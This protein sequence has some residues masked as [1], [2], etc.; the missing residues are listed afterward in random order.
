MSL[1]SGYRVPD[2]PATTS[3]SSPGGSHAQGWPSPPSSPTLDR[4]TSATSVHSTDPFSASAKSASFG[5]LP[6]RMRL[7]RAATAAAPE[8]A[9]LEPQGIENLTLMP[10]APSDDAPADAARA[11][12]LGQFFEQSSSEEAFS[13]SDDALAGDVFSSGGKPAPR[14]FTRTDSTDPLSAIGPAPGTARRREASAGGASPGRPHDAQRRRFVGTSPRKLTRQRGAPASWE[15]SPPDTDEEELAGAPGAEPAHVAEE[16]R[17]H[18]VINRIYDEG[19][20]DPAVLLGGCHVTQVPAAVGDLQHYVAIEPLRTNSGTRA[21]SS[22]SS[23]ARRRAQLQFF[24]WDNALTRLPSALFQL[25]NL[26]VLSLRKNKLTRLPPAIGELRHLRELN[27]GGNALPFLPAEVQRLQLDTFTFTPNPFLP[28]PPDAPLTTRSAFGRRYVDAMAAAMP[29]PPPRA[30][31]FARAHSEA[32]VA[33]LRRA[34]PVIVRALGALQRTRLPSLLELCIVRLLSADET[35]GMLLENYETGCLEHLRYALDA[36]VVAQ[37]EA[38]RRSAMRSWGTRTRT[39]ST[40]PVQKDAWFAGAHFHREDAPACSPPA[41][42][43][44]SAM[45][46]E[47]MLEYA[48]DACTNPWF[49]RDPAACGG[50]RGDV[51]SHD[52]PAPLDTAAQSPL[53]V[54][55]FEQRLE[56]VSHVAGVRVAKQGAEALAQRMAGDESA[57]VP[58]A[59]TPQSSGCVPLLWRGGSPGSLAFLEAQA[60]KSSAEAPGQEGVAS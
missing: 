27:V 20:A 36:R 25:T 45:D 32:H 5:A 39:R 54:Q 26:G 57:T 34:E 31:R 18:T 24:L 28:V 19:R 4:A 40:A 49:N 29:P 48:D 21:G 2:A 14:T 35:G 23:A 42:A 3:S 37:L 17:W 41:H 12:V 52:W 43:P 33:A 55:P 22:S 56:W 44:V 9:A 6:A 59:L 16:R 38:A 8:N 11:R 7:G 13:S 30:S 60:A 10:D 53:F 15:Q 50:V 51:A 46:V 47:C 58:P 1:P